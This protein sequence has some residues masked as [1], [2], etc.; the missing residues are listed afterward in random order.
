MA[1][2]G[3]LDDRIFADILQSYDATLDPGVVESVETEVPSPV[4]PRTLQETAGRGFDAGLAGLQSGGQY[5]NAIFNSIIGDE[6]A[7]DNA[8]ARA[9]EFDNQAATAL[10]NIE[11]FA[12]FKDNPSFS[13]AMTQ[14]MVGAGQAAPSGLATIAG[15]L[16]TGG[17]SLL[18]NVGGRALL[19]GSSK[20][21]AKKVIKEA[22]ENVAADVATPDE[23]KLVDSVYK[24]LK[25]MTFKRGA[26][27]GGTT[28][29]YVPLSGQNFAEGIEAGRE[30]DIDLALRSLT[31]GVPQ[32]ALEIAAPVALLK[33]L[34]KVAKAKS[35]GNESIM[36]GL[37]KDISKA[38]AT[39]AATEGVTELGQEGISVLNRMEMDPDYSGEEAQLRLAQAFMYGMAG[40]VGFGGVGG[41]LA[42][43]SRAANRIL[44]K[45]Q[46]KVQE[47][48]EQQQDQQDNEERYGDV[49]SGRTTPE[50]AGTL[51]AQLDAVVNES[52][53]KQAVWAEGRKPSGIEANVV[54]K[55]EHNGTTLYAA[56]LPGKGT[57]FGSKEV[58]TDVLNDGATDQKLGEVLGYSASKPE[59][60]ASVVVQALDDQ[61]RI[62]SEELTNRR[63]KKAAIE[64]A[65]GLSPVGKYNVTSLDRA[66]AER[67]KRFDAEQNQD[68]EVKN[69]DVPQ[70]VQEAFSG[71][72]F[73]EV[74]LEETSDVVEGAVKTDP[75]RTFDNTRTAREAYMAQFGEVN[76][77]DPFYAGM[78]E[79]FLQ[80][81]ADAQLN[82]PD[83]E[84]NVVLEDGKYIARKTD[85]KADPL[86]ESKEGVIRTLLDAAQSKNARGSGAFLITPDGRRRPINLANLATAGKNLLNQRGDDIYNDSPR[87]G[88]TR[89][90]STF[91]ADMQLADTGYDIQI[92]N[93]SIFEI[94]PAKPLSAQVDS[95]YVTGAILDNAQ[96][97]LTDV[98]QP[99]AEKSDPV[100][101]T[102]SGEE[103]GGSPFSFTFQ[104]KQEADQVAAEARARG[105]TVSVTK[106]REYFDP[107][108]TED[109]TVEGDL[110]AV[111]EGTRI[112]EQ[113]LY[114]EEG[115]AIPKTR[116]NLEM[117]PKYD[118]NKSSTTKRRPGYLK[119]NLATGSMG[120]ITDRIVNRLNRMIRPT[121][122]VHVFGVEQMNNMSEQQIKDMFDDRRVGQMVFEQYEALKNSD[123]AMGRYIS[124]PNA[125]VVMVDNSK[126]NPLQTALVAA[127]EMGHVLF[128]EEKNR[129]LNQAAVRRKLVWDYERSDAFKKGLDFEEWFADQTAIW[130]KAIYFKERK[131]AR[132][133]TQRLFKKIAEKLVDM[134]KA[135]SPSIRERLDK[136]NQSDAFTDY[137]DNT[138]LAVKNNIKR[139]Q[140]TGLGDIRFKQKVLVREMEA[141][142]GTKMQ[143]G[144]KRIFDQ[145]AKLLDNPK[146]HTLLK[147]ILPEDNMLRKISPAIAD[148]FYVQSNAESSKVGFIK[149]KD[150]VRGQVYKKLE[151]MLGTD[152]N[153]PEVQEALVEAASGTPTSELQNEKAKEIRQWLEE[154]WENYISKVPGNEIGKRDNYFPLVLDLHAISADPDAFVDLIV[155][156]KPGVARGDIIKVVDGL[157]ARQQA[158]LNEEVEITFDAT[159]PVSVIEKARELTDGIEPDKLSAFIEAPELALMKYVRHVITRSEFKRATHDENG[160]NLLQVEL[161]KL[162]KDQQEQA[163]K[164]IE[165][166][167]GYTKNPMNPKLQKLQSYV[168]LFNWVTLLPLATIGSITELGGAIVNTREFNGFQLSAKAMTRN[169]ENREQVQ[170]LARTIGVAWSTAMGNIGLTDADAEYLDPTVR[171]WSDKFFQK[172]GL[173]WFT[174]FTREFAS[175]TGVEFILYH[176]DPKTA[177]KRSERY[178]RDHGVT[179]EQVN[180]WKAAQKD[181][182]HYTFDGP[183]GEAV[184]GALQ[185]FV[186]NSML[187][188]NAAERPAWAN[189]PR[190]QLVWALKSYLY[191]FGKVIIGGL[192]REMGKRLDEGGTSLDMMSAIGV[193]GVLAAAAFLPLAMLSLELRELAKAGM[194]G[195]LPGVDA[196]ARYFRS[197]RMDYG[198]YLAEMFDRAGFAGPLAILTSAFKS[199]EWGQTGVGAIFGPT[200]GLLIDDIGMGLY[201]GKGWDIIPARIIPGYSVVL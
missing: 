48:K 41:T 180:K 165:R 134:W 49:N 10:N 138:V 186:E 178:L 16:A 65:K 5:F 18:A 152:W 98:L 3:V 84:F 117:D 45:A 133:V 168:Q 160:K 101:Y 112:R 174:R 159:D 39:G 190:Y 14:F 87:E 51:A 119:E 196:N 171:K 69:M 201:R 185:R 123:T 58:V 194:A 145:F 73:N 155:A 96:A 135:V 124:F 175:A 32:A 109:E 151:E 163:V 116:L 93:K 19:A 50:D 72:S 176:A 78:T 164:V 127:H 172:I 37:V 7:R 23:K 52:S 71:Q 9:Q 81:A 60:G 102:V 140:A 61:G 66:L 1:T 59:D 97:T 146:G 4:A 11:T 104:N 6:R 22:A 89:G 94:D 197:D 12:E 95:D 143:D 181:G 192:K 15:A 90:L 200:A 150:H 25:G 125:H 179:A 100:T 149:A 64:A 147:V 184:M 121:K 114:D 122:T 80:K 162:P 108:F 74:D 82:N 111:D 158:V 199:V 34:G 169:L 40:G 120:K 68:P 154:L 189:D 173:D 132:G 76:W 167:L 62:V 8:I 129:S 136:T 106:S 57:I 86:D 47:G 130:A 156:N 46:E 110:G 21:A 63:G 195:V 193:T 33:S 27:V 29:G 54:T 44:S 131:A 157:V 36:G 67:K 128:D 161:D 30:P 126:G 118:L 70:D 31:V 35:V 83:A 24:A 17:T 139:D 188:P 183:E 75:N 56:H 170:E 28:A 137:I 182:Q 153:T 113:K 166:Y 144:V 187:R 26:L 38:V 91:L 191:S 85:K 105:A 88:A 148:M 77:N 92:G 42:G 115:L 177:G 55:F 13:G 99:Q 53:T 198:E 79:T 141:A 103:R 20:L 43:G 107:S 142:Q 2:N